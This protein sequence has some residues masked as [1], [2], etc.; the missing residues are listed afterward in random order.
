MDPSKFPE[1]NFR[2]PSPAVPE[3]P[4]SV[5]EGLSVSDTQ[6]TV[7]PTYG[8]PSYWG[9]CLATVT[10]R[11]GGIFDSA[12]KCRKLGTLFY[13]GQQ[14]VYVYAIVNCIGNKCHARRSQWDNA[15]IGIIPLPVPHTTWEGQPQPSIA[16]VLK[17]VDVLEAMRKLERSLKETTRTLFVSSGAMGKET[18]AVS[19][20]LP[21]EQLKL[22]FYQK[23]LTKLE[24]EKLFFEVEKRRADASAE[25]TRLEMLRWKGGS[26][27]SAG[28]S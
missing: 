15:I 18:Y 24:A 27:L 23:E 12:T 6:S 17:Q 25:Q 26:D 8:Q 5:E 28:G 2:V 16:L 21:S 11:H 1:L 14:A 13:T 19:E 3:Y 7:T 20:F 10:K 22:Q 9:E 4:Y